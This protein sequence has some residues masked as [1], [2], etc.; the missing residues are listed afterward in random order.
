L[1][2][3][4]GESGL[5]E[6][7]GA[8]VV[9]SAG[10]AT[11][12]ARIAPHPGA[13]F[14]SYASQDASAA[15]RIAGA[16]SAARIEVWFDQSELRGGDAW[17]ESI[18]KQ[19]KTCAM[20]LPVI[21]RNTHDRDEG[22]FRL[23]WKLAVDRCHLMAAD[24]AFLL[25]V[26]IDD[27][28]DDDER[29]PERFREVQWTRLPAGVTPAAFVE[30][31]RRLLSGEFSQGPTRTAS[32]DAQVSAAQ[33]T[34]KPFL[35]SWQS[36]AALLVTIAVVVVAIGYLVT[37]RLVLSKRLAEVGALRAAA[38]PNVPATAFRPPLHSIAVLP[39]VNMSGDSQQEYFS[40][41]ISEELI[42]ALSHIAS[43]QVIARTSSFSFKGQQVDIDTIAHK[44]N[45]AAVLEGSIRRDQNKV[46]ITVQ[47]IDTL[48]GFHIWSED[49]DRDLKNILNLQ[50]DIAAAVA[51]QLQA[52]LLGDEA[53]QS[54]LGGTRNPEALDAYLRGKQ[55]SRN[56]MDEAV[57]MSAVSA[58]NKA[59]Q[60]DPNFAMAYAKKAVALIDAA[61]DAS[62]VGARRHL[63]AEGQQAAERALQLAPDLA[64]AH[65]ALGYAR[66]VLFD[67]GGEASEV[68]RAAALAPGDARILATLASIE[69]TLD[70]REAAVSAARRVVQLDPLNPASRTSLAATLYFARQFAEALAV[71]QEAKAMNQDTTQLELVVAASYLAV[72]KARKTL[73]MF[74]AVVP[75]TN[76][77]WQH[78]FQTMAY[79]ALGRRA[80]ADTEL[81][82]LTAIAGDSAAYNYAEIYA[83][84][85]EIGQGLQWLKKAEELHDPV[86]T[87]MTR[88]WMVDPLRDRPEFKEI[89]TRLNIPP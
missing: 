58:F 38:V 77:R 53:S 81:S 75:P 52:K 65:S 14:I 17:D 30:R 56:T 43:L 20:F 74:T 84:R 41:G 48:N 11:P 66:R 85:A 29:V 44:L 7:D 45:V 46:R 88:D 21:S 51:R 62:D 64:V 23:E 5:A 24:K 36:K 2:L 34:R 32:E 1:P 19:I 50:T 3:R 39:F 54:E 76:E 83:Q 10:S 70:Q 35:A 63:E 4:Q 87:I 57:D 71:A 73:A 6:S 27:A 69:S 78:F 55:I 47:L 22:Y 59:I 25:P 86:L 13:V 9:H 79:Q 31:V 15:E 61:E 28:R 18:R 68:R 60:L 8:D 67:Y 37:T 42:N 33:S 12:E 89:E 82:K 80:E 72:G 16:L 40:D 26:V 49:Y